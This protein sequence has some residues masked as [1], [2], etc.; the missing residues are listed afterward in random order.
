[1]HRAL[2]KTGK[3]FACVHEIHNTLSEPYINAVKYAK[4]HDFLQ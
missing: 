4:V 2:P 3:Q 1:M